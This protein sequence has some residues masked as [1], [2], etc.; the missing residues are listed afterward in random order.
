MHQF[1]Y[2]SNYTS[3]T[4]PNQRTI[5]VHRDAINSDFLGIKNEHWQAASRDLSP[6]SLLL[7]LYIASNRDNFRLALSPKAIHN[8]I[9]M[10]RTTY[11]EQ[12]HKLVSKGYIVPKQGNTYEFFEVPRPRAEIHGS[13][14][15]SKLL[16]AGLL[17]ENAT[18]DGI[19]LTTTGQDVGSANTEINNKYDPRQNVTN[20]EK[21]SLPNEEKSIVPEVKEIRIKRPTVKP[22]IDLAAYKL[23]PREEFVF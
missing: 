21:N 3:H 10:P 13:D 8:A 22:K 16:G 19:D 5:I 7:Y 17:I 20:N 12:F 11:H 1:D 2:A 18:A 23:P 4:Y 6:H 14:E 9:G 15:E